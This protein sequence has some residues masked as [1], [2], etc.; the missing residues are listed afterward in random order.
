MS[1]RISNIDTLSAYFDRL[2]TERIKWYFFTKNNQID[3][4]HHQLKIIDE[5]RNKIE[6]LIQSPK[7][8]YLK[9]KR[10]FDL[11]NNIEKLV[12]FDA[13]I[14]ESDRARL[15]CVQDLKQEDNSIYD[16][17]KL[18]IKMAAQEERLRTANE[19]RSQTKNKIDEIC[20]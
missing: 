15:E 9:E 11:V 12:I 17:A 3:E 6:S 4:A 19:M 13:E 8:E 20:S 7:Y 16:Q 2:V 18:A 14:G 10:T 5:I 1:A